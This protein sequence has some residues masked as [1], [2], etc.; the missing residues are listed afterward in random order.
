MAYS[1]AV[2][3]KVRK[4]PVEN[5]DFEDK[6]EKIDADEKISQLQSQNINNTAT[7]RNPSYEGLLHIRDSFPSYE[8]S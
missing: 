8:G 1:E 3:L 5:L 7:F 2:D 4:D 6:V